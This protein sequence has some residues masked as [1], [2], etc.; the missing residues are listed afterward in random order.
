M[1]VVRGNQ[2]ESAT[3]SVL[4]RP[5]AQFPVVSGNGHA[6]AGPQDLLR[7]F[8]LTP[9]TA[10]LQ[11]MRR[12]VR[13]ESNSRAVLEVAQKFFAAHQHRGVGKPQFLW[14]IVC[15]S[16]PRVQSADV[17]LTGFSDPGFR[18]VNM[19]QR[20]FLAVDLDARQGVAFLADRFVDGEPR[21]V[22]RP[23]LDTLF[24]MSAA[25][26]G[27]TG[28]SA[29]CIAVKDRGV[30]IF[31]PPNSGKTTACYLAARGGM[32]FHADQVVFLDMNRKGLG[33]WGDL[34]PAVFRPETVKFL[35]ELQQ[36]AHPIAYG[37]LLFYFF[38]KRPLR[39]RWARPISPACSLFLERCTASET[40]VTRIGP[41]EAVSRLRDCMLF[42]ED[43]GFDAQITQALV[44]LAEKPAYR[45]R[46]STDPKSAARVIEEMLR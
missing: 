22:I 36:T 43:T 15:E 28:V 30:L 46:Y 41:T 5:P 21:S 38:D 1:P 14:R 31:G 6:I 29:G 11:L 10:D 23:P 39:A 2:I 32:E 44:A 4:A 16:D 45:V 18:Y 35:P 19:G 3:K 40:Q 33:A 27:L 42:K 7:R 9:H 13:L 8:T 34:L 37:D 26:L 17:P 25:S 12:T 24:C 20:S